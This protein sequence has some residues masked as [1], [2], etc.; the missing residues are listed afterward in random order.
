MQINA[1]FVL[2]SSAI[3]ALA[4]SSAIPVWEFLKKEEKTSYLYSIFARDVEKLCITVPEPNCLQDT[5]KHGLDKLKTMTEEDLDGLDPY[6]H[7]GRNLVWTTLMSGHELEK[8]TPEPQATTT[9][10]PNSYDDELDLEFGSE[11]SA[12]AKIDN[13]Y[14]VPPPKGFVFGHPQNIVNE[15][16][17]FVPVDYEEPMGGPLV[18]RL[19][20]DGSPVPEIRRTP[21]D[22]DF[23]QYQLTKF[24]LPNV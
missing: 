16:K 10:K 21:Q 24:K 12:S 13:V 3:I 20:P 9:A 22:D 15:E 6:Q 5:L 18:I 19:Y 7:E 14:R 11:G 23:R 2:I 1:V 4:N 8:A 17:H